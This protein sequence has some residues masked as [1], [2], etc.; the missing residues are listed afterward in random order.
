VDLLEPVDALL[1]FRRLGRKSRRFRKRF[2]RRSRRGRFDRR[3]RRAGLGDRRD[4][5]WGRGSF[6]GL[7]GRVHNCRVSLEHTFDGLAQVLQ[8][9]PAIR[10]LLSLGGAGRRR[11]GVG[12]RTVPADHL[13]P[14]MGLEPSRHGIRSTVGEE[15][16]DVPSFQ[17]HDDRAV[18]LSLA[19]R[20]IIDPHDPRRLCRFVRESLDPPE[21]RIGAGRDRRACGE[22]GAGLTAQGRA[23][24][25]L[26]L[27]E[28]VGGPSPGCCEPGET[29]GE[30]AAWAVRLWANET[31]DDN[32]EPHAPAETG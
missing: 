25:R 4:W 7:E 27:A 18:A 15:V 6:R 32:L 9:V 13:D 5:D 29:L 10:N 11:L 17:V 12:R 16:E 19:P 24:V 2:T 31:A 22:A 3:W 21:Q 28:P 14:G 8:Q 23:D 26:R 1:T 20:P 30:D